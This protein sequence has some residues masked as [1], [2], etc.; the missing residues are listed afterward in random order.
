MQICLYSE[1]SSQ[2]RLGVSEDGWVYDLSEGGEEAF[3]SLSSLLRYSS[4]HGQNLKA[5]LSEAISSLE[6]KYALWQLDVCPWESKLHLLPP[7]DGQEVWAAGVT[8][9]MSREA[10]LAESSSGSVYDKVY[11]AERPELFLKATPSRVVGPN[12]YLCIRRDSDWNAPEPELALVIDP[13]LQLVGFTVGNDMSSREIEG[14]N[15]L[16]LPQ[17]KI[18][19]RCCGLGPAITLAEDIANPYELSIFCTIQRNGETIFQGEVSTNRFKRRYDELISYLGRE[20]AFP[21]GVIL[22][23]GTGIV[24]PDDFTL[25]E[26]DVVSITIDEIGTLTNTVRL[27]PP[28]KV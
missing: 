6:P 19:P 21:H 3:S 4:Q 9:L 1:P 18:Y 16:Y 24:P 23:T 15:P 25:R 11:N 26:G 14:E 2:T 8:Y 17:A 5:V 20:N 10:R 7:I 12:D 27:V 22:L 28:A 13:R